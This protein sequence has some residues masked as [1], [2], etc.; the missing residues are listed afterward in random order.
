M[1]WKFL[2]TKWNCPKMYSAL[3][4]QH[5]SNEQLRNLADH[6]GTD[7][8]ITFIDTLHTKLTEHYNLELE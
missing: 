5:Y 8:R 2:P 6:A 7:P 1:T 4:K 3:V